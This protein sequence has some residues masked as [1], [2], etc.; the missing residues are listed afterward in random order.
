MLRNYRSRTK[1]MHTLWTEEETDIM[2]QLSD[3]VPYY[4]N[5]FWWL[6]LIIS[7][8]CLTTIVLSMGFWFWLSIPQGLIGVVFVK[9]DILYI[10]MWYIIFL[11]SFICL[12]MTLMYTSLWIQFIIEIG[13]Y[14]YH[15]LL[16]N[17]TYNKSSEC[18]HTISRMHPCIKTI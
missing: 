17:Q 14:G 2:I 9:Y 15:V 11:N 6:I 7:K 4:N 1:T 18:T 5:I 3:N 12:R 16:S 8:L 10:K 13:I